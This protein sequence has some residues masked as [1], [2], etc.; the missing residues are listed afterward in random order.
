MGEGLVGLRHPIEVVLALESAALL[1]QRVEDLVRELLFHVL[2]S[3]LAR[4]LHDPAHSKRACA[5][6]GHLDGHL[7]VRAADAPRANLEHGRDCLHRLLEHLDWRAAGLF[8]D[9]VQRRVH[10]LLG[11]RLLFAGHDLVDYLRHE[12][13]AVDGIPLDLADRNLCTARHQLTRLAPYFERPWRRSDTPA[14]SSAAR[15]TL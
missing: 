10:D 11:G 8:A 2:L 4:V 12:L 6:L 9:P 14:E 13:R 1:V 7:V 3:P 5:A 15:M